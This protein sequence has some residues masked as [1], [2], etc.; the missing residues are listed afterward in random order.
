MSCQRILTV[1][2][3]EALIIYAAP[4]NHKYPSQYDMNSSIAICFVNLNQHCLSFVSHS[5]GIS[6]PGLLYSNSTVSCLLNNHSLH[7]YHNRTHGQ[8]RRR[9]MRPQIIIFHRYVDLQRKSNPILGESRNIAPLSPSLPLSPS[10]SLS[11]SSTLTIRHIRI[12]TTD[13]GTCCV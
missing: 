5:P 2:K 4:T 3:I 13:R 12:I 8:R 6:L 7:F 11:L 9:T 10:Q 1:M